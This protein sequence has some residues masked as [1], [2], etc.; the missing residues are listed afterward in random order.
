MKP[1]E[2]GSQSLGFN[3]RLVNIIHNPWSGWI[4]LATSLAITIIAYNVSSRLAESQAKTRFEYRA[5]EIVTA[6]DE[7][8]SVYEQVLRS[9]V[10]MMY[11]QE[12]LT[13][14]GW[15][16]FADTLNL[17]AHWPGIQ[18][19]GYSV[20]VKPEALKNHV[21]KIRTEG[22]PD[23]SVKPE[24]QRDSY[25]AII[26]LEPFDWRNKRAFGYD[27]WSNEIRREAMARARDTGDAATSGRITLVQETDTDVQY[28]FLSYLPVYSSKQVPE[29]LEEK[30][31]QHQGWVYAAFRAGD[32]MAGIIGEEDPNI[33]FEIFDG[34]VVG[35]EHLLFDS[36]QGIHTHEENHRPRFAQVRNIELQGRPWTIYLNTP[37][38]TE[39]NLVDDQPKFILFGGI[40]IDILLFYVIVS[41]Y[42]INK[43]AERIAEN[44][45]IEHRRATEREA[46]ANRAKSQFLANMS[47]ELR[48]PLN[49][50][51][52]YTKI[53]Q[54]KLKSEIEEKYLDA[55]DTVHRN[56]EHLLCLI[57]DILDLSKVEAG[58]MEV[59][60]EDFDLAAIMKE[61]IPD[62]E[63]AA[64][65]K[66]LVFHARI[67]AESVPMTSDKRKTLQI[68]KNLVSNAIK[69]TEI[70]RVELTVHYRYKDQE[71][72]SISITDTGRGISKEDQGK[73]FGQYYRADSVR[74]EAVEGTGLGLLISANLLELIGGSISVQSEVGQG[75][76]FT[77]IIP[78]VFQS[79][80][81]GG[82]TKEIDASDSEKIDVNKRVA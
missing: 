33:E 16:Q 51:I 46:K 79:V 23:Y 53:L 47:H 12:E 20:P 19:L 17:E 21:E 28:G 77:L 71:M 1:D 9:G 56:G 37:K 6:I 78:C 10:A 80:K 57:N 8:L 59:D 34:D 64:N 32:L 4:I 58:K 72:V 29:T 30:R 76:S 61:E 31:R 22:F 82:S 75:S 69:Y 52:G 42:T 60:I 39:A 45:T 81:I 24:G 65:D 3:W 73:L 26:F 11:S 63:R 49:S 15:R 5:A 40:I 7:R 35:E 38:D 25:S 50:I 55:L 13:R 48:T 18:G 36:N 54:R 41:L 74:K 68:I 27:M 14:D 44:L 43:R 62:W 67:E 66:S 2:F 70:G